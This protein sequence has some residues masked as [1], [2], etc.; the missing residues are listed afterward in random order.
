MS[1]ERHGM[2][3]GGDRAWSEGGRMSAEPAE[4]TGGA[5]NGVREPRDLRDAMGER[6][7]SSPHCTEHE[8]RERWPLG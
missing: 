8:R 3:A 6:W 4:R 5:R 2:A 7:R 1:G